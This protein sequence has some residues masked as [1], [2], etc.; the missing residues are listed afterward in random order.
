MRERRKLDPAPR[1]R[2]KNVFFIPRSYF[3]YL[4]DGLYAYKC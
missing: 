4:S 3:V 1:K 2:L